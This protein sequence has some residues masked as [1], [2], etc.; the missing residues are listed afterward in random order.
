MDPETSKQLQTQ[1]DQVSTLV[2]KWGDRAQIASAAQQAATLA[3]QLAQKLQSQ[4]YN[5]EL[6]AR[7]MQAIAG[8]AS[9]ISGQ[10]ERS[11]E[12]AAMAMDA[13]FIAYRKNAKSSNQPELRAAINR[14]F[15][16]LNNPSAYNAPHFAAE[17]RKLEPLLPRSTE[18]AASGR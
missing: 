11:A 15:Q 1:L 6:T 18:T 13:L 16:Q 10:G 14:L 8:D 3:G 17:L 9:A 2:G 12:Q 7:V 5:A 4:P